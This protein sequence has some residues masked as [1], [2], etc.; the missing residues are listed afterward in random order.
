MRNHAWQKVSAALVVVTVLAAGLVTADEQQK[1]KKQA[2]AHKAATA[3][4]AGEEGQALHIKTFQ[5]KNADADEVQM[6]LNELWGFA[7]G[8]QPGNRAGMPGNR[9]AMMARG[10]AAPAYY[11]TNTMAGAMAANMMSGTAAPRIA[12]NRRTRTVFVRGTEK[13]L[14]TMGDLIKVLESGS[15]KD[16]PEMKNLHVYHFK[17][18]TP[19]EAMQVLSSLGLQTHVLQLPKAHSLVVLQSAPAWDQIHEVLE[20]LDVEGHVGAQP[21]DKSNRGEGDAASSEGPR[22]GGQRKRGAQPKKPANNSGSNN[23]N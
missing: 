13:E 3:N 22:K 1:E 21:S 20:Q 19:V 8:G 5:L 18:A 12:V 7:A 11:G 15:D 6:A 17:H 23:R 9:P 2:T 4:P 14:D 16:I 10:G